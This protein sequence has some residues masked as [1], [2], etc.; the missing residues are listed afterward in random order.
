MRYL[1]IQLL[2]GTAL[3]VMLVESHDLR[4]DDPI[5]VFRK[6]SVILPMHTKKQE[7]TYEVRDGLAIFQGDIILGK[8]KEIVAPRPPAHARPLPTLEQLNER[9][10]FLPEGIAMKLRALSSVADPAYLWWGGVIPYEI[11]DGDFEPWEES[12][13]RAGVQRVS[14]TNLEVILRTRNE[15]D[16]IEFVRD[17]GI[18]GGS[19]AVGRQS[20]RQEIRLG[21]KLS[22]D[23]VVVQHELL[24]A[25][26]FYHEHARPDRDKFITILNENIEN[27]ELNQHNFQP[28]LEDL[29]LLT[30]YDK[31]SIM[32]YGGRLFGALGDDGNKLPTI[33]DNATSNPLPVNYQLSALDIQ[34][35][36]L[37]YPSTYAYKAHLFLAEDDGGRIEVW[38]W[39]PALKRF[40]PGT[41]L[42]VDR[43]DEKDVLL[44][45]DVFDDGKEELLVVEDD[46][47]H[48]QVLSYEFGQSPTES[49]DFNLGVGV[50]PRSIATGDL[51]GDGKE[52]IVVAKGSVLHVWGWNGNGFEDLVQVE[53]SFDGG[54]S[55]AV[56]NV[57]GLRKAQILV[58]EDDGGII[59]VYL[60]ID[61]SLDSSRPDFDKAQ[62]TIKTTYDEGDT[63][64]VGD[65]TYGSGPAKEEVLVV[66]D[67]NGRVEVWSYRA[68]DYRQLTPIHTGFDEGDRIALGDVIEDGHAEVVVLEDDGGIVEVWKHGWP[69]PKKTINTGYDECDAITLGLPAYRP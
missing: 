50:N 33:L 63:L 20:G 68:D 67:D 58:A 57:L 30:D 3:T 25:A 46:G 45:A 69:W 41:V 27:L 19:S 11:R 44:T 7:I 43:F 39:N 22:W 16:Y 61:R 28:H 35:V 34:G 6:A 31:Q 49:I 18:D 54:D 23:Y 56:G 40:H 4:A 14:R 47:G 53:T 21:R 9:D 55:L 65:T 5:P 38:T 13:I 17:D 59:E 10:I 64:M 1:Y 32:H 36:N 12:A 52:E 37:L 26:G 2:V 24:H 51:T 48:V 60:N 42:Q 62:R 29:L 8:E 15:P 66:E